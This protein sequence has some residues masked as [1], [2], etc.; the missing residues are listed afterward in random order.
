MNRWLWLLIMILTVTLAFAGASGAQGYGSGQTMHGDMVYGC[1]LMGGGMMGGGM[2]G[3]MLCG[4]ADQY[5]WEA[6]ADDLDL[7]AEQRDE[8]M[9]QNRNAIRKMIESRNDLSVWMFDLNTEIKQD[10]PDRAKIESLIEQITAMQKQVLEQRVEV[11][12]QMRKTLKPDQWNRF[13]R[14]PMMMN[15]ADDAPLMRGGMGMRMMR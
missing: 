10:K 1:G 9:M 6:I 4:Q 8:L 5:D 13:K 3:G 11:V 12:L 14:M 7:S 2:M 15:D